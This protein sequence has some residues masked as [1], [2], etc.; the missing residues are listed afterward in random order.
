MYNIDYCCL[1][2]R[3][4]YYLWYL[5]QKAI[6]KYA[7]EFYLVFKQNLI[8]N[9]GYI[10]Q[11]RTKPLNK[12]DIWLE[13][14]PEFYQGCFPTF[15]AQNKKTPQPSTTYTTSLQWQDLVVMGCID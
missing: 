5:K 15:R 10:G 2:L 9:K 11:D 14:L 12:C 7:L 1:D 13:L 8:Y 3:K 6:K 4:Y